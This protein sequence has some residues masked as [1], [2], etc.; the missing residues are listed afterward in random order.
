MKSLVPELALVQALGHVLW[1]VLGQ[2]LE[3]ALKSPQ[4]GAASR[5]A[6]L[7]RARAARRRACSRKLALKQPEQ[8][9]LEVLKQPRRAMAQ[10]QPELA[11]VLPQK[12]P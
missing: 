10:N 7:A 5:R 1:L 4:L 6:Y 2:I 9:R 3:Q 8:A 12:Q 11:G